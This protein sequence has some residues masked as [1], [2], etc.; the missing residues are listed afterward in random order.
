M[1]FYKLS[2]KTVTGLLRSVFRARV[3]GLDH[4]PKTGPVIVASNH[5]SFLDSIIISAMMPR[6]VAFLAKAEYR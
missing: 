4:F 5:L 2:Q 1:V 3:T 6:R